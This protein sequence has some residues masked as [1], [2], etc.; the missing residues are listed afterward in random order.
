LI[1]MHDDP[2]DLRDENFLGRQ[3]EFERRLRASFPR[4]TRYEASMQ[5]NGERLSFYILLSVVGGLTD[6]CDELRVG[7]FSGPAVGIRVPQFVYYR[8]DAPRVT[9]DF[10]RAMM[11]KY[12]GCGLRFHGCIAGTDEGM[13]LVAGRPLL[14]RGCLRAVVEIDGGDEPPPPYSEF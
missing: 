12:M 10:C 14:Q 13:S 5:Q 7:P 11:K 2:E 8:A 9:E 1:E 4:G 6:A 3:R